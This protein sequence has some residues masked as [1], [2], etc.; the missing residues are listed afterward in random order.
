RGL[1]RNPRL[2]WQVAEHLER[3]H[4]ARAHAKL[5]TSHILVEYDHHRV[6]LEELLAEVAGMELPELVGEDRPEHPLDRE[7]LA[8]GLSR[9]L[10]AVLGIGV[11]TVRR[12]A[13]GGVANGALGM[14]GLASG[15]ISLLQGFPVV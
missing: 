6:H 3:K 5:L 8:Q 14:A 13:T 4:G 12:L 2:G 1:D 11:L 15:A 7:P 9:A 10:G